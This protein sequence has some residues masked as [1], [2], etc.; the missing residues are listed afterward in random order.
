M[1]WPYKG[2]TR[3]PLV[4]GRQGLV[5][6]AHSLASAVGHEV[7]RS[8]GNAVDAAVAVSAALD[9]TEPFMS[10]LGGGG[11]MLIRPRGGPTHSLHY[12]GMFPLA[13]TL[14]NLNTAKTD[15]GPTALTVPGAPAGW[16]AAWRRFG[17]QPL[18]KLLGPAIELAERGFMLT[19]TGS[20]L[21]KMGFGRLVGQGRATFAVSD[22]APPPGHVIRQPDLA[23]TYRTLAR[24]GLESFYEGSIGAKLVEAIRDAGGLLTPE[25]LSRPQV[26]WC[27]PSACDV[28]SYYV[29]STGWPYTSYETLLA[30]KI[31]ANASE[32]ESL[33]RADLWHYR[34]EAT[35]L[36]MADRVNFGGESAHLAEGLLSDAYAESRFALIKA[37]T[38]LLG[39]GERYAAHLPKGTL[40]PGSPKDFARECTTHFDLV[41]SDGMVVSVT[42]T[43]GSVFGSGFMA[44]STGVLLNNLLFFFDLD[45]NS[46]M[47][48]ELGEMRSGPLSPLLALSGEE[49]ILQI[50][51]PGAFGIPQTTTQMTSN[52]LDLQM[53]VQAAVEAPRFRL[54][55]GKKIGVERRVGDAVINALKSRGHDVQVLSGFSPVV[56][57]GHGIFKDIE[58]GYYSGGAD[59]RRDGYALG[60]N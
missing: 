26:S 8:G 5:S 10:G 46:P 23:Q 38:A 36:A 50:G 19:P 27:E 3:R 47:S 20:S 29:Q 30:L 25:D 57:G 22:A 14:E 16:S 13:A 45:P 28:G 44:G 34:I 24:D 51:T 40:T 1:S 37:G 6:C 31:L 21:M 9:V 53:N 32:F 4:S 33:D 11:A 60:V 39:T 42:Q 17:T 49:V 12:G 41:D 18:G 54:Y 43:L 56:G 55:G 15:R 2:A 7:L 58:S 52:V 35:K 59:P 48:I